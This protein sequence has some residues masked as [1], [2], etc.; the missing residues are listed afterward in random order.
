MRKLLLA[1]LATG[2][3]SISLQAQTL[4]TF[5]NTPVSKQEFLRVYQKNSLN[6]TT[7]FSEPALREYLDLYSLFRMKVREAELQHMDTIASISSEL[8]NYRRQLSKNYL[9]DKEA[10]GRLTEEAYNR[11]KQEVHVAHILISCPPTAPPE[12]T[13]RAYARIDSV[14]RQATTGKQQFSA[15]ASALSDDKGTRETGGDIGYLTALQTFYPF[16]NAAYNTKTGA[17]SKPFR[18]QFG[19]HIVKVL[20]TRPGRGEVQVAQILISSPKSKGQEGLAAARSK[21]TMVM[22]QLKSGI[23]FDTL[24]AK[25]SDDK[26]SKAEGGVLPAFSVGRMTP[27]FEDA[28][29]ALKQPGDVSDLVQTEYGYHIIKLIEKNPLQPFDSV[30]ESLQRRVDNDSRAQMAHDIFFNKV[31]QENGF[32]EYPANL[33]P[34]ITKINAL[35]DTGKDANAFTGR[36]FRTMNKPLFEIGKVQYLQS[37]FMNFAETLTRGR[38]NGPKNAVIRDI[39]KLYVERTVNDFEENR[40]AD[41]NPDFRNLMEEYRNGIMLFELTD[42][43]VWSKASKDTLGLKAFYNSHKEKYQ[44]EPGFTGV[45]YKFKNEESMNNGIKVLQA[46]STLKEE[47]LYKK[48]NTESN[49][50]AVSIQRGHYEFSKFNEVPKDALDKG[51][52]SRAVKNSDGTYTVVKVDELYETPTVKSLDDARGYAVAEYQ[53]YLEKQWNAE[54]RTKYPVKVDEKVFKSMVK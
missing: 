53:D 43:N 5:G 14:Y 35:P 54:L 2:F 33:E 34:I 4:F 10:R 18:T 19:Y 48:I 21:A 11:M 42:R 44:W 25:Y 27:A 26:F 3:I 12:D 39:Y 50:D 36:D 24:V 49:P 37:D 32:K 47:E 6:K 16:E 52:L 23:P 13:A 40:L 31:K 8:G 20:N 7:D 17:I 1:S 28:A 45:V 46:N 41:T 9:T 22:Q 51:K 30:R 38:I 15:L 29:F